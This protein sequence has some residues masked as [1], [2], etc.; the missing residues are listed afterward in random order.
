MRFLYE[1]AS[2]SFCLLHFGFVIFWQKEIGK[3][4]RAHSVNEIDPSGSQPLGQACQ[5]G[6]PQAAC[7]PFAC[8]LRPE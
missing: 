8:F 1:S 2:R 7:G 6:G 5:T 4:K 3:K